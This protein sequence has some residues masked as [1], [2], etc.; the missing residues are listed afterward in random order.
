MITS[1][2]KISRSLGEAK[3]LQSKEKNYILG[4]APA[5]DFVMFRQEMYRLIHNFRELCLH[6]NRI[7]C[8]LSRSCR[9][10]F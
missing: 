4:L 7:R 6:S 9:D 10:T 1:N 5:I 3:Y 2:D 8:H